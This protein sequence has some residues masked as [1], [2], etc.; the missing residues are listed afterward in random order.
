MARKIGAGEVDMEAVQVHPT[1]MIHPDDP[2]AKVRF[3]AAEA[4]RGTGGLLLDKKGQRFVDELAKRDF[5][6]GRMWNNWQANN[7]GPAT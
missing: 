7:A 2:T 3:L 4:L 5:T 6:T 1:G